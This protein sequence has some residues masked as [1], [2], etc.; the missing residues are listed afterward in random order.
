MTPNW[1]KVASLVQITWKFSCFQVGMYVHC[2]HFSSL[3]KHAENV[4]TNN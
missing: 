3:R 1:P 4:T 2:S